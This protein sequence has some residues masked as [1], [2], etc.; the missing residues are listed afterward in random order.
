ML[1]EQFIVW[2][3]MNPSSFSPEFS[4]LNSPSK[5]AEEPG[6]LIPPPDADGGT[7][8]PWAQGVGQGSGVST[9]V[10]LLLSGFLVN[11]SIFWFGKVSGCICLGGSV[12]ASEQGWALSP[13]R[14]RG[15]TAAA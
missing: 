4:L 9:S 7:G 13:A 5:Q 1:N 8:V 6:G 12:C 3:G 14:A 11:S 15:L 10:N 2:P